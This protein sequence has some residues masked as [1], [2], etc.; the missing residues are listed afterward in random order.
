[1]STSGN[2][3]KRSKTRRGKVDIAGEHAVMTEMID[4]G[5]TV[6]RADDKSRN[7]DLVCTEKDTGRTFNVKVVTL[8]SD[9]DFSSE[10][11]CCFRFCIAERYDDK[12]KCEELI[13]NISTKRI[14]Y[15]FCVLPNPEYKWRNKTR[16]F[17]ATP[18][19]VIPQIKARVQ[20]KNNH[21]EFIIY[22]EPHKPEGAYSIISNLENRWDILRSNGYDKLLMD[23]EKIGIGEGWKFRRCHSESTPGDGG[24]LKKL[25]PE[26]VIFFRHYSDTTWDHD[27]EDTG[28]YY[29]VVY[30]ENSELKSKSANPGGPE[31][32]F[33]FLIGAQGTLLERPAYHPLEYWYYGRETLDDIRW[34][35]DEL[36][37]KEKYRYK[38]G[39]KFL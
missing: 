15:V 33:D 18:E 32:I 25:D 24:F 27:S 2:L 30:L 21:V 19:K 9:T 8:D 11:E 17:V 10:K 4:N 36:I 23:S 6:S 5:L 16:F 26:K 34:E 20:K 1:M 22:D 12:D 31:V 28:H 7:I 39:E 35:G 13:K 14:Y 29:Q 37:Y 3:N 38:I